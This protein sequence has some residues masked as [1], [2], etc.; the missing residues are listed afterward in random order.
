[1]D[2]CER[3]GGEKGCMGGREERRGRGMC[4]G[5]REWE[6]MYIH[7]WEGRRKGDAEMVLVL[8]PDS[9][10]KGGGSLGSLVSRLKMVCA[11]IEQTGHLVLCYTNHE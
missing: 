3:E 4:M 8:V 11:Q 7:E 9:L 6:W 10:P 5:R 1:M 2:V